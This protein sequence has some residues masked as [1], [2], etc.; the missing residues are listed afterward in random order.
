MLELDIRLDTDLRDRAIVAVEK[1]VSTHGTPVS[2]S[3]IA[4]LLQIASNEP[5][6]ISK[7][8]GN[9]KERAE[10]R[11]IGMKEGV[12]KTRLENEVDFWKL[13]VDLCAG[14]GAQHAWSL[15]KQCESEIPTELQSKKPHP[16]APRDERDSYQRTKSKQD[17]WVRQWNRNHYPGFFRHFCAEYLYRIT[18]ERGNHHAAD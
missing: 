7:Y 13:V 10:K 12:N 6:L 4:G 1:F 11:L 5:D 8:A 3:Q 17:A 16:S 14:K 15:V 9:Q 18:P 2:R